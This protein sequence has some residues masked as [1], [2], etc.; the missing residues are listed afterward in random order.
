MEIG[1]GNSGSKKSIVRVLGGEGGSGFSCKVIQLGCWHPV[2][3]TINDLF[4]YNMRLD[5]PGIKA[6]TQFFYAGGHLVKLDGFQP[7]ISFYY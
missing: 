1:N 4:G 2:V 5:K 3:D 6:I 7:S